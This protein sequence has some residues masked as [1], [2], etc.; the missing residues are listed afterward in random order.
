[1]IETQRILLIRPSAL[2]DV[3]RSI[4]V[5]SSLSRA[6]PGVPIDWVVQEGFEDAIRA[7]P[8]VAR[9]IPFPRRRIQHWW[10]S[11]AQA[12]QAIDFF[13]GLRGGY[14]LV[15]DAQGL[16]RSGLMAFASGGGRRIGFADAPEGAWLAY[17]DRIAVPEGLHAVDRMLAMLEGA[18][19]AP[20]TD[21]GLFVPEDVEVD[22]ASWR[23]S[24][25]GD[26]PYIALA[27]TSRWVSKEWPADHWAELARRL[28]GDGHTKR[29][30]LLGGSGEVERLI[31]IAGGRSGI[32]ILAGQGPLAWSMAAVRDAS[33]V[34]ANDS[35]MLHAAAGFD[36]P[37]VGL[38]GPTDA[39][40]SGPFGR[41]SDCITSPDADPSLHYRDRKIGDRVMRA[42]SVDSVHSACVARLFAPADSLSEGA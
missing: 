9:A 8:A 24:S 5:L 1:M 12:R 13:R 3:F 35:A 42:I 40:I 36:V 19:I 37:L 2:G 41:I 26:G 7:H 25:I 15:V 18:G 30:V 11:P 10:R 39:S 28:L 4:P 31:Q 33:L 17:T 27:P 23:S 34:V 29:I 16:A 20:I 32:E 14:H 21:S 22:W 6:F 38:F